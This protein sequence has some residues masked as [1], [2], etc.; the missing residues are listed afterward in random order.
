M[1]ARATDYR[2]ILQKELTN[3]CD[4]NPRYS[5][6]AFARDLK[7]SPSRLSEILNRKQGLSRGA[8]QKIASVL[9]FDERETQYFC[10]L[11]SIR[12]ARSVKER[13]E[14]K[15]RLLKVDFEKERDS[16]FQL[17]LDAFKI[18]SDWYHLGILELMKCKDFRHDTK[19]IARR[20]GIPLI[21]IELAV[22]RLMR[23]GLLKREGDVYV[24]IQE[25][26]WVPGG[27]PS[28]SIRKFH[29]QV[30]EKAIAAMAVQPVQERLFSTHFLTVDRSDLP[31]A[32]EAIQD[33]QRR[34]C[35]QFQGEQPREL[36]YCISMQLFKIV[37]EGTV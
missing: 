28:G 37:E 35:A 1:E 4:Q 24:A 32:F 34:F 8:A 12:H 23:V 21:Q 2:L 5:L 29:R 27:V 14:A 25:D 16:R 3:R 33:F 18:I 13:E 6:R 10:D 11:V 26:G 20:L 7:L 9:G 30:L 31:A 36:L 17:Q 19:W 15:L 22:D